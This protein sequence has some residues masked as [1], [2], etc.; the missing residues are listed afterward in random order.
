MG[1]RSMVRDRCAEVASRVA[2]PDPFDVRRFVAM[3]SA[4]RD[5]PIRL[6]PFPLPAWAPCGVCV[7]TEAADY[8][9]VTDA[10][11]SS[12]IAY[13]QVVLHELSHLLLEHDVS[14]AD[15]M[16]TSPHLLPHLDPQV[17]RRIFARHRYGTIEEQEAETLATLLRQRAGLWRPASPFHA[18]DPLLN[19]LARSLEHGHPH[20]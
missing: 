20:G 9:I 5:R 17:V 15:A 11:G 16:Q 10:V 2:V 7:S 8:V 6:V 3:V 19:R 1:L 18:R 13:D 12:G 14:V 4:E